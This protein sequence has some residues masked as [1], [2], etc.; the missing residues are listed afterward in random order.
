[1]DQL[2]LFLQRCSWHHKPVKTEK[3]KACWPKMEEL[4]WTWSL[5]KKGFSL[6]KNLEFIEL[7]VYS[8]SGFEKKRR[9]RCFI[10]RMVLVWKKGLI[11]KEWS[12]FSKKYIH[13]SIWTGGAIL[14]KKANEQE[15]LYYRIN[16][17]CFEKEDLDSTRRYYLNELSQKKLD[18]SIRKSYIRNEDIFFEKEG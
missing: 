7:G 16:I 1:M 2:R 18:F 12:C 3:T 13:S 14:K 6:K 17:D 15:E 9:T 10:E 5:L 8:S 11:K 4:Y